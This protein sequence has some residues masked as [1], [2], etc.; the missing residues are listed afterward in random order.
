MD[1]KIFYDSWLFVIDRVRYFGCLIKTAKI[2]DPPN[3]FRPRTSFCGIDDVKYIK[4]NIT[5]ET[6]LITTF[7]QFVIYK[8]LKEYTNPKNIWIDWVF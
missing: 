6:F 2:P 4:K 7:F 5:I 1:K 8:E 3:H